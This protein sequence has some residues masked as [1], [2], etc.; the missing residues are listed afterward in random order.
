MRNP[1]F[2]RFHP[3]LSRLAGFAKSRLGPSNAIGLDV[4]SHCV[5]AVHLTV[6]GGRPRLDRLAVRPLPAGADQAAK[7]D[8]IRRAL[9]PMDLRQ[10]VLVT[11]VG[12][13]GTVVRT[14][15]FP[16][17]T[18]PE[19]RSAISF[20]ADK[21][22]PFKPEEVYLDAAVLGEAGPGRAE[23][24][25]VAAR[26][27]L[28][29]ERLE[30]LSQAGLSPAVVDLEALALANAVGTD[31]GSAVSKG[32]MAHLQVGAKGTLIN[33]LQDGRLRF[34][35]EIPLG[36]NSFTQALSEGLRIDAPEAE[37]LKCDP[38][39]RESEV[40]GILRPAWEGWLAECKR[41]FDF[42]ESQHGQQIG[43]LLISG[44]SALSEGFRSWLQES[45]GL[46]LAVW[47]PLQGLE[48]EVPP[49]IQPVTLG[50]AVG[51]ALRG[52]AG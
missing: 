50:V 26:R 25:V 18:P 8:E 23:V 22:L 12:G 36:G 10:A 44:G 29:Q 20:E 3:I 21:Y 39:G 15:V 33:L 16:R 24:L 47:D 6:K 4:G 30:T 35:R 19:L 40:A 11:A 31:G 9:E 41:S 27:D 2:L 48:A 17:M 52:V 45:A 34:V 14:A 7:A 37:R 43:R 42:Y 46:P 51:L 13:S 32:T 38:A 5:K 49:G 1:L 28:I